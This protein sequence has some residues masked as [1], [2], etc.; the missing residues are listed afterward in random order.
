VGDTAEVVLER[1]DA[2]REVEVPE[3]LATALGGDEDARAA[4]ESLPFTHRK[5]YAQWIAGAKRDETRERRVEKALA[6]L[7]G[8]VRH[9]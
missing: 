4:F 7:R 1:D 8:G 6:M 2:P 9:P 3:A 5:E